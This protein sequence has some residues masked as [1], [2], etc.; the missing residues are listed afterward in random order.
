M[1]FSSY[2]TILLTDA[3]AE[4]L[5]VPG[6]VRSITEWKHLVILKLSCHINTSPCHVRCHRCKGTSRGYL[7]Q[8]YI[9]VEQLLR[10]SSCWKYPK[11]QRY[12]SSA[13][14]YTECFITSTWKKG[15]C[16]T[17][18]FPVF[19]LMFM[20]S[21]LCS[22]K[23]GSVKPASSLGSCRWQW[24]SPRASSPVGKAMHMHHTLS[25][26]LLCWP[27]Q[28][29]MLVTS[30]MP[31]PD[32]NTDLKWQQAAGHHLPIWP[33]AAQPTFSFLKSHNCRA[34]H[35]HPQVKPAYRLHVQTS[36][37]PQTLQEKEK[38]ELI[39]HATASPSST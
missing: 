28:K 1:S 20:T 25:P 17:L 15:S 5:C 39:A 35:L 14:L 30:S 13:R 10:A 19:Q 21:V 26:T 22:R 38:T 37:A 34:W 9:L 2:S 7:I 16:V 3:E 12:C 4:C 27:V 33:S 6:T 24:G 31:D 29:W 32:P 8:E 11:R 23:S 18:E 36:I